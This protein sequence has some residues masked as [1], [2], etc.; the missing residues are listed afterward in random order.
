[1]IRLLLFLFIMATLRAQCQQFVQRHDI[2]LAD[3]LV[4]ADP[5]CADVDNDGLSDIMLIAKTAAGS[6]YLL[7]I[8][9]DTI[10]TPELS[11]SV[12]SLG[13]NVQ[14]YLW[15][16]YDHDN[17]MDLVLSGEVNMNPTVRTYLNKGSF[18][19][20][21][22][23][24]TTSPFEIINVADLDN[25]GK[26]EWIVS[27][28]DTGEGFLKILRQT[29]AFTWATVNDSIKIHASSIQ[30]LDIDGDGYHDLFVSGSTAMG[31]YVN[32]FLI[33]RKSFSLKPYLPGAIRGATSIGDFNADGKSDVIL[34]GS[35]ENG[36]LKS[37]LFESSSSGYTV[38]DR[39]ELLDRSLPFAADFNSDGIIE[40]NSFGRKNPDDTVNYIDY[41]PGDDEPLPF[42]RVAFQ[43]FGD[44]DYDGDLDLVQV[45]LH[46][47][48][49]IRIFENIVN[50]VNLPPG[51]P[52][53]GVALEIFDR[54]FFYWDR[55][56]DDHTLPVS[57]TYDLHIEGG[58]FYQSG[59]FDLL[60]ERRLK[61]S[62]GNNGTENFR[63][64]RN[65]DGDLMTFAVQ[66]VD[67][68]LHG[69]QLCSGGQT[70][71]ADIVQMSVLLCSNETLTL[72]SAEDAL[73]F[74]FAN[75]FL[76]QGSTYDFA[77]SPGDTV[78][79]YNPVR[80]GCAGLKL[81]TVDV[82][83]DTIRVEE[84]DR[85]ACEGE[86]LTFSVE[87]GWEQIRWSSLLKGDLGSATS[88]H[89][90]VTGA[91]S[92]TVTLSNTTGCVVKRKTAVRISKPTITVANDSYRIIRG[93]DVQLSS[94]GGDRYE[95]S[96]VSGL[97][98]STIPNPIASPLVSTVYT[99]TA[100]DSLGC[101]STA[102]VSVMVDEGGFIPS[103]FTPN[104]DGK[105]DD[106]RIY[107]L[108][109]ARNF[110]LSVY[111]REGA[112]VYK[113]SNLTDAS[114]RGWDGTKNGTKQPPG[115]YFWKVKG[116]MSS[117]E[118]ILLNG[119]SSGSVVL[120]R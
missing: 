106:L 80:N 112:L 67:N 107:G 83:D 2:I 39:G 9:G 42:S 114:Q 24:L 85:F 104:E 52:A 38:K 55:P 78:F 23:S 15:T 6:A 108:P 90:T 70:K 93:S 7:M 17:T 110:S 31:E 58:P 62:Q 34:S 25:D 115:V 50:D 27:G 16:D 57:L 89:Y 87:A 53:N 98:Q 5:R 113:T 13:K 3:S 19:F 119:K 43:Q 44:S 45:V 118:S 82:K 73:W 109:S 22:K 74:S 4:S 81:W 18:T 36:T 60:N 11:S 54:T 86:E 49:H 116:E 69:G 97:S 8:K 105:N 37:V 33:N 26:P 61:P 76:K 1:M 46:D 12:V 102:Q 75:G 63:L 77:D 29:G 10:D 94:S 91:D 51:R 48:I 79:A 103:L 14:G 32:E 64:I 35:E 40:V 20:E 101:Q 100:F 111:N 66:S 47:A 65:T 30:V 68:S 59:S 88:L 72:T 99:V 71:C 28:E 96:P 84:S 41:N 21:E 56:S 120:V 95:W 92:V 117:G